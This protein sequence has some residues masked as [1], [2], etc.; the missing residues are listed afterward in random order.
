MV[1]LALA[2][3][4]AAPPP[5][6]EALTRGTIRLVG[7]HSA[8]H[9]CVIS[10]RLALT[11]G[12]IVDPRPFDKEVPLLPYLFSDDDGGEGVVTPIPDRLEQSRDL[13]A[14]EPMRE[15]DEFKH[16]LPVAK[17][18]PKPGDRIWLLGYSWDSKKTAMADDPIEAKVTRIVALH[19]NFYPSGVGGSSGSCVVNDAGEVVGIN[20]GGWPTDDSGMAGSAVG[21][22]GSLKDKLQ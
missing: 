7:R 2:L 15:E 16:Y 11:N 14:V 9:A 19:I 13:A 18:R 20:E 8:G 10:P 3:F 1:S 21:V 4:L 22:W 12:H 5:A 17:E 6:V